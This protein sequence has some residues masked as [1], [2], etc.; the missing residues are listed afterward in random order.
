MLM[1]ADALPP[2]LLAQ[3]V[4]SV[5]VILTVG[6]PLIVPLSRVKPFGRAGLISQVSIRFSGV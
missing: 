6:V 5:I 3:T 4:N 2:V 1:L